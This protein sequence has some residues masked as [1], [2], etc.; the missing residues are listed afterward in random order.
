MGWRYGAPASI[1]LRSHLGIPLISISWAPRPRL[2]FVRSLERLLTSFRVR[3]FVTLNTGPLDVASLKRTPRGKDH[4]FEMVHVFARSG[5]TVFAHAVGFV[6][7][8]FAQLA[9]V[10]SDP[11]SN[12]KL[13]PVTQENA[14]ADR[15]TLALD[16]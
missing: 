8:N 3:V 16:K 2:P 13:S 11:K 1:S 6:P 5:T 15:K 14:T 12:P 4:G 9:I 10:T 7:D